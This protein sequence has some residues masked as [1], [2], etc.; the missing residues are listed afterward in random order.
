[1]GSIQV[2]DWRDGGV[3]PA[4]PSM[5]TEADEARA[6]RQAIRYRMLHHQFD[7]DCHEYFEAMYGEEG[8]AS[9]G[10]PDT[11]LAPLPAQTR[12]LT[13]PGLYQRSP[14]VK[15]KRGM[16]TRAMLDP[17]TGAL[18]RCGYWSRMQDVMYNA[19]GIGVYG[20]RISTV[21]RAGEVIPV[22]RSVAPQNCYVY[23]HDDDP[24][25]PVLVAELRLRRLVNPTTG[26]VIKHGWFWDVF[27]ISDLENPSF[28]IR[29]AMDSRDSK[30]YAP[31]FVGA[32]YI[33]EAYGWRTDSNVPFIPYVWYHAQD[34]GDFWREYRP[35]LRTGTLR[36]VANWTVT[37]HAM[38]W[39]QGEHNLIGG[40]DPNSIPTHLQAGARNQGNG[41]AVTH[42]RVRPG[43]ATFLPVEDERT[44]QVAPLRTGVDL[45]QSAGFANLYNMTLAT[46]DGINPSDATR[47][48]ANPTSAAALAISQT[49]KRAF[50]ASVQPQFERADKEAIAK[51]AWVMS[52]ESDVVHRADGYTISYATVP[53]T[54]TEQKEQREQLQWEEDHGQLSPV[55][56]HMRLHPGVSEDQAFDAVVK[57]AVDTARVEAAVKEALAEEGLTPEPPPVAPPDPNQPAEPPSGDDPPEPQPGDEDDAVEDS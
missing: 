48:S 10:V 26:M 21:D 38:L 1:M 20:L 25:R 8:A 3:L 15:G 16:D 33:G 47:K 29:N 11:T 18:A 55:E 54:P 24:M 27:D 30:D 52:A 28:T 42:M 41:V 37:G 23:C 45:S 57:A 31:D 51:I 32:S 6:Q 43:M 39:A 7:Q 13:T 56:V 14:Q 19:V 34:T 9:M 40:V 50:A 49:D 35:A 44:L 36:A 22:L 4:R 2:V 12:Q 53:L 46:V 17:E 5:P